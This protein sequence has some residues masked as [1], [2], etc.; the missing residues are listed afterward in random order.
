MDEH[1][2]CNTSTISLIESADCFCFSARSHYIAGVFHCS[3]LELSPLMPL[4]ITAPPKVCRGCSHLH[5]NI[6]VLSKLVSITCLNLQMAGLTLSLLQQVTLFCS[7]DKYQV[8]TR[9]KAMSDWIKHYCIDA[10]GTFLFHP[11]CLS[12]M[13]AGGLIAVGHK[14]A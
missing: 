2:I 12:R 4:P 6:F 7:K 10:K 5:S 14:I 3:V 1:R 13:G 11:S 8:R 9:K